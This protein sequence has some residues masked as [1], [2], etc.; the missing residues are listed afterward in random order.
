M[1][2]PAKFLTILCVALFG[3]CQ[4][5][6]GQ[7]LSDRIVHYKMKVS[8][9]TDTKI[10]DGSIE[11]L[12]KNPSNDTISE[13]QFH[14]YLNAFKNTKSTF[15]KESGGEFSRR[16]ASD[17]IVW[18]WVDILTLKL[19]D[20][21]D[22][23]DH[24]SYIQPDDN[25]EDDQT[26]ISVDL[27]EPVMPGQ[28]IPLEIIFR[29]KLPQ[30]F[31]RTGYR[32][33]FYLVA[34][35]FPKIGVYEPM[36][37]RYAEQG[38]WNCHQFHYYSEFY[39]DFGLY[40]VEITLPDKF[41]VGATGKLIDQVDN[42]DETKTL[43]YLAEDVID[44]AWTASPDFQ[45]V[46]D[47][48]NDVSILV[49]LQPDHLPQ[50]ERHTGSV[51]VALEYFEK[52]L[53]MYPYPTISIIDPPLNG[54]AA[55]G[56]EYP[57]FITAGCVWGMPDW[58]LFTENVGIHEFGHN[59]FMGI[60]ASNEFEEAWMDEG[61][62]SYFEMRIMDETFGESYSYIGH[63]KLHIGNWE[64]QR[65]GYTQY[66][67]PKIA[68]S[69]RPS[70]EYRHG[71]YGMA[72]Y[73]KPSVWLG[74][75]DRLVG[76]LTMDEIMKAYYERWKFKH[77]CGQDFI[78]VV[79]EVV[80]KNHGAKF[81]D[82][83][84]WFFDQ[85]LYGTEI[86]DYKLSWISSTKTKP[87]RGIQE[88]GGNKRTFKSIEYENTIYKSKVIIQRLGEVVMPVEIL[89]HFENGEEILEQWDGKQR[90]F[91]LLYEKTE[92]IEW[93]KVDPEN[94][95]LIDINR[96]NNSLTTKPGRAP[97]WRIALKFLFLLQ[98][99]MQSFAIFS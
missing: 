33:D 73:N 2:I 78:D 93:A 20:G 49:Y 45:L 6:I 21:A 10:I 30:I 66:S 47:S 85:V 24:I 11:L 27:E 52:Y 80:T 53:G 17:P 16:N 64:Y 79:N 9:D 19:Q 42:Q 4:V 81:G 46:E 77:P 41:I 86:C 35:W 59:Y 15:F 68:E 94:K 92:R 44:F 55:S 95:I 13:L 84:D 50:A 1:K 56:M 28:S 12:W 98:N 82:N 14:L 23:T 74:T 40:E 72:S 58:I 87:P 8:L 65:L 32:D 90:S 83:M 51:K 89:V 97:L 18:G 99:A 69:F 7:P 29:S 91:E 62:D 88:E 38:Q 57:T 31:D 39:A 22:L 3:A 48:W 61:F 76:R 43:T 25:N 96:L 37:M 26:V 34:Q 54:L 71:G 63:K 67:N 5:L 60:L 75:L 36:G 70:W